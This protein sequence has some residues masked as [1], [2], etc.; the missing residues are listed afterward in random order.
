MCVSREYGKNSLGFSCLSCFFLTAAVAL[1]L[2]DL[3]CR[4]E[5]CGGLYCEVVALASFSYFRA[6]LPSSDYH[7]HHHDC[8]CV[9]KPLRS[10]MESFMMVGCSRWTVA[11]RPP[12]NT[13]RVRSALNKIQ[14][15]WSPVR[16]LDSFAAGQ[17]GHLDNNDK[18]SC[19]LSWGNKNRRLMISNDVGGQGKL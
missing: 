12:A 18:V 13:C 15:V 11:T 5:D 4:S 16:G 7:H 17:T 1:F 2:E 14:A 9:R 8:S 19:K 10:K 6:R 3:Q